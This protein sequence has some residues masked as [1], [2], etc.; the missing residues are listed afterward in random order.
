MGIKDL[1]TVS[2]LNAECTDTNYL[3]IMQVIDH[4]FGFSKTRLDLTKVVL[5]EGFSMRTGRR[6]RIGIDAS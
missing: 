5:D 3:L 1:W 4:E 2:I 6:Q